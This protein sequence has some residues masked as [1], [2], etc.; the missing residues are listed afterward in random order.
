MILKG[1]FLVTQ[2]DYSPVLVDLIYLSISFTYSSVYQILLLINSCCIGNGREP[3][4]NISGNT[5]RL[6]SDETTVYTRVHREH[7]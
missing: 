5:A 4:R 6:Q 1:A 3:E 7:F 2:L